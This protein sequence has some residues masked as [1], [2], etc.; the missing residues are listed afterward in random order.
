MPTTP[1]PPIPLTEI[2]QS[3]APMSRLTRP[4]NLLD[5]CA[6]ALPCGFTQGRPADLAADRRA[7]L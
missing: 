1:L 4:I 5:L 6:L 7:Q 2:D 3:K